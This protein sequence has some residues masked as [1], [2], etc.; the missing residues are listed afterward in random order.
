[1]LWTIPNPNLHDKAV[2]LTNKRTVG[3]TRVFVYCGNPDCH[4]NAEIDASGFPDDLTLEIRTPKCFAPCAIIAAP[5][6][7]RHAC[8]MVD[9][10]AE[11][12]EPIPM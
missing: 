11:F 7:A 2:R 8:N 12:D 3:R 9:W 6:S 4:H 1:M 10:A 5:T